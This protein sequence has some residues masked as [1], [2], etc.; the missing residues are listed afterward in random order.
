MFIDIKFD[1]NFILE[2]LKYIIYDI[3][4]NLIKKYDDNH[5][6]YISDDLDIVD[7]IIGYNIDYCIIEFYRLNNNIITDKIN[8]KRHICLREMGKNFLNY[9]SYPS[10][11]NIY[12]FIFGKYNN[13]IDE[14]TMCKEC[15]FEIIYNNCMKKR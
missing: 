6:N 7:T 3:D 12:K 11:S 8:N 2:K 9:V 4:G 1:D 15:Y 13:D 5:I 10:L 14:L